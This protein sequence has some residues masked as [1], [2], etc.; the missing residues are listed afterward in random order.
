MRKIWLLAV[1]LSVISCTKSPLTITPQQEKEVVAKAYGFN[2]NNSQR[3]LSALTCIDSTIQ[4]QSKE[5]LLQSIQ[6]Y[7]ADYGCVLV[8]E[9]HT[10]KIRAMVNLETTN[11]RV[12]ESKTNYCIANYIEPGS[13]IKTFDVMALLEDKKADTSTVYSTHNGEV[14]FYGKSIQDA[15]EGGF[16][17]VSLGKALLYSSNTVFAQAITQAYSKNP[18]HFV[19]KFKQFQLGTNLDLPF[20]NS[21]NQT[22]PNPTSNN[23]SKIS[24]PWMSF[25]YG[26]T[27]TPIQ[28][29]T[30]YNGI[31]NGGEVVQPLFLSEIKNKEGQIKQY[32]KKVLK[33][34]MCSV[35]TLAQIQDLLKKVVTQGTGLS[36]KS[37]KVT[38]AGKTASV[39]INYGSTIGGD[40][41]YLSGFVGF[42]PSTKPK[43]SV[44]AI[45]GNPKPSNTY[46]GADLAGTV[47]RDIAEMIQ[48][49]K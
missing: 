43:Y 1:T 13:F 8:M 9:T 42:F 32:D 48:Q 16:G 27:L 34:K 22:I 49:Q 30:Y 38:I 7:E 28:I 10:G 17:D 37:K 26:L 41:H 5:A 2:T 6:E 23:W 24:L 3:E 21:N 29:L 25:G 46:Y 14:R 4:Q 19:A 20:A 31:A 47:V 40:E 15:H 36:S 39:Q 11:G 12:N 33:S 35:Q 18:N 44:I 45:I